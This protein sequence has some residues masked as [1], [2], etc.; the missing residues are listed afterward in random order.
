MNRRDRRRAE[1]QQR[2]Q[3]RRL[4]KDAE[5]RE[6]KAMTART[7]A[8]GAIKVV[9]ND[10]DCFE[11]SGTKQEAVALQQAYF[12]ATN[13]LLPI[14]EIRER[15]SAHSYAKRAAGYLMC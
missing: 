3:E 15:P 11:W 9:A 6:G 1:A 10:V 13:A 5:E 2:A 4:Q 12:D 8:M 14:S 7:W